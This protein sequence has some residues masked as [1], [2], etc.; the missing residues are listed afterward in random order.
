M[1]E[2]LKMTIAEEDLDDIGIEDSLMMSRVMMPEIPYSI[3]SI[4]MVSMDNIL[5]IYRTGDDLDEAIEKNENKYVATFSRATGRYEFANCDL[6]KGPILGHK[7]ENCDNVTW[8]D[9][10]LETIEN[11]ILDSKTFDA[12]F[13]VVEGNDD[14]VKKRTKKKAQS[15]DETGFPVKAYEIGFNAKANETGF[16]ANTEETGFPTKTD[17]VDAIQVVRTIWDCTNGVTGPVQ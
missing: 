15:L 8:N 4:F 14:L 13:G 6:C 5:K 11:M 17:N 1:V 10:E 2:A 12:K 16:P 3:L 7:Q 9:E